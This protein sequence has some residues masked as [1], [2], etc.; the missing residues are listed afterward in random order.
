MP[1]L[2]VVAG[3]AIL[4]VTSSVEAAQGLLLIVQRKTVLLPFVKPL[5]P[6]VGEV[7][8]VNTHVP[9]IILHAP[10]PVVG[11]LPANTVTAVLHS[12]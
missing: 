4:I 3:T 2:A 9:L 5:T 11:L 10:V 6:L 8:L 12:S 1:A 7:V